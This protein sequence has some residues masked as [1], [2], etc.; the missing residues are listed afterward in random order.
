MLNS[1]E[2][3]SSLETE[4]AIVSKKSFDRNAKCWEIQALSHNGVSDCAIPDQ[5]P[6]AGSHIKQVH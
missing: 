6:P 4:L 2:S 3:K 5:R 1:L